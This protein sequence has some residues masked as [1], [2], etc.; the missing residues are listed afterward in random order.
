MGD[1][2]GAL[3]ESVVVGYNALFVRS[4]GFRPGSN[5]VVFGAGPIG[6]ACIALARAAGAVTIVALDIVLERLELACTLGADQALNLLALL[7]ESQV[8][9]D[10][11]R[12]ATYGDGVDLGIEAAGASP[13]IFPIL[14]R[15]LASGGKIVQVGIGRGTTPVSLVRL[16]Q[17]GIDLHGSI[18]NSG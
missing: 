9:A 5:V 18:G 16:Q 3:V 6:L 15:V 14:E 10:A 12:G 1:E 4:G 2:V 13:H 17:L 7:K 11:I 8:S